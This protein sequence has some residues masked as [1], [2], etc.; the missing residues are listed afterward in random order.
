MAGGLPVVSGDLPAIRE[1]VADERTGLVVKADGSGAA[2]R[3]GDAL[4]RLL[5]D[6]ALRAKLATGGR[7]RVEQEFALRVNVDRLEHALHHALAGT[8]GHVAP[9][10]PT[11]ALDTDDSSTVDAIEPVE[12]ELA[13]QV[14]V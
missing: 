9:T 14:T 10:P 11:Q 1:L 3:V 12:S 13:D 2:D 7:Q 4:R 6:D 8:H 5:A